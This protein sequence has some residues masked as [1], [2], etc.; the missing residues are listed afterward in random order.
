MRGLNIA[1]A[2]KGF[3]GR[4]LRDQFL[5]MSEQILAGQFGEALRVIEQAQKQY[6][7][8][9]QTMERLKTMTPDQGLTALAA[10]WPELADTPGAAIV[11]AQLQAELNR[12]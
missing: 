9:A 10:F 2:V 8:L 6:P 7:E 12:Q 11:V 4:K 5:A 3:I 1:G